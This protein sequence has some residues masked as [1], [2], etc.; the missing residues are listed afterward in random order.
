MMTKK[1]DLR[2]QR[3]R[4]SL[5]QALIT[6]ME[7]KTFSAITIQE[8]ADEAM[9]NRATFYLHYCDKYDLLE[10]CVKDNLDEI[11]LK[12]LT[13]V[14]HIKEGVFHMK[15]F[16]AIVMEILHSVESNERFFQMMIQSN[17]DNLIKDY[18]IGLVHDNF[19]PQLGDLSFGTPSERYADVTIQLIVSAILGVITWW[20]TSED[21]ESPEEIAG[22]VVDVVTKGPAY[23]FG[24]KTS[25]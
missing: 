3:T 1:Q 8:L 11:M 19:L 20:I 18:F 2:I 7:K 25:S 15:I 14:R 23:V 10:K 12:H 5:N 24:L 16:R 6:L 17:C 22:I 4:K 9:I 21:R 13:P